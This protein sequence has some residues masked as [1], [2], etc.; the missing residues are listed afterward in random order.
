MGL[1]RN[2]VD[3]LVLARNGQPLTAPMIDDLMPDVGRSS[4]YAALS[5]LV[6]GGHLKAEWVLSGPQPR[7]MFAITPKGEQALEEIGMGTYR[8]G[9]EIE[10]RLP[11]IFIDTSGE[12]EG[13]LMTAT[14]YVSPG[15]NDP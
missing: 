15:D 9:E 11:G 3:I 7:R 4:I 6:R 1:R 2:Q 12:R 14:Q 8:V 13:H 5:A 10:V